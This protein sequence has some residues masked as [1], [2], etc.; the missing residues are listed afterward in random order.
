MNEKEVLD[1]LLR[2]YRCPK[3]KTLNLDVKSIDFY[4]LVKQVCAVPAALGLDRDVTCPNPKPMY[5][6]AFHLQPPK[7]LM[8]VCDMC[9]AGPVLKLAQ[10]PVP[11]C[12]TLGP[13]GKVVF[14]SGL[15][16]RMCC[17]P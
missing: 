11:V 5:S 14:G 6:N 17:S 10:A 9:Q 2:L 16:S 7:S 12:A 3:G 15:C 13:I 8:P 4:T 1:N